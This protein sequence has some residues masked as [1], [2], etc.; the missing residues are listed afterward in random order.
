[1]CALCN[2]HTEDYLEKERKKH[3]FIYEYIKL[4][5]TIY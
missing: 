1:M 2:V 4:Y 3:K 5:E